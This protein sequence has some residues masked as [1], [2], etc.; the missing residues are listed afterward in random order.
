MHDAALQ[1]RSLPRGADLVDGVADQLWLLEMNV[2]ST[3]LRDDELPL[4][5]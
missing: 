1:V 5:R 4:R 3:L 2:V